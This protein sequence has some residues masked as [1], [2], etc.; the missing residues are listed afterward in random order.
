MS[1][2]SNWNIPTGCLLEPKRIPEGFL[3]T[4]PNDAFSW[5]TFLFGGLWL[6]IWCGVSFPM[7]ITLLFV[8]L[9]RPSLTALFPLLFISIFV[10]I[11][12][13]GLAWGLRWLSVIWRL[14]PGEVVLP[15]YPLRLGESSPIQYRRRLRHGLTSQTGKI[16]AIWLCYEWIQYR[17]GTD[18][19]TQTHTLWEID[20]PDMSIDTGS[21]IIEYDANVTVSPQGVPSLDA[22]HNQ[23]RWE[24]RVTVDVPGLAKDTSYFRFRV[25]PEVI[26]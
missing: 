1:T 16:T 2:Q 18:T 11:G 5:F 10:V 20:L 9:A 3:F 6:T 14:E 13:I 12:V 22:K 24:I 26:G 4:D 7:F 21:K 8:F 25:M 19:V 17:R 15:S 23:I